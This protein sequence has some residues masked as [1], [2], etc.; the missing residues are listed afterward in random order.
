MTH[1]PLFDSG[2]LRPRARSISVPVR[3]GDSD[4]EGALV[5][6]FIPQ[7]KYERARYLLETAPAA[8]SVEKQRELLIDIS[9]GNKVRYGEGFVRVSDI[10]KGK[11]S[12]IFALT[13]RHSHW[14]VDEYER[15]HRH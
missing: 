5:R 12:E 1:L 9:G 14:I 2:E 11:I 3:D 15:Q 8:D 7:I 10:P 13:L 6:V 4:D